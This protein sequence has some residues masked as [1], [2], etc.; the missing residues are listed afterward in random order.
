MNIFEENPFDLTKASD[1]SDS[2]IYNYWVDVTANNNKSLIDLIK[3][4]SVMPM[5]L[6]GSKGCGK[7]H[8]MRYCS[9]PVQLMRNNNDII[10]T[11][12]KDRYLGIYFRADA[13]NAGRFYGK[14][15]DNDKWLK[16]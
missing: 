11:I 7:T 8:L 1:F 9:E 2:E 15:Q 3:P 16:L 10:S 5:M 12:K 14:G 6:L 13:L 4:H